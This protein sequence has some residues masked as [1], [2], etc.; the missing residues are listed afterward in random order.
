MELAAILYVKCS[1]GVPLKENMACLAHQSHFISQ[2]QYIDY[3]D[4]LKKLHVGNL[5]AVVMH[6]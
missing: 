5:V 3:M 6:T 1:A 2:V 4:H